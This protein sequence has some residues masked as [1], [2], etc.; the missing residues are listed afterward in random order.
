MYMWLLVNRALL[1]PTKD[2]ADAGNGR[3]TTY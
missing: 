2:C 3:Q 1:G